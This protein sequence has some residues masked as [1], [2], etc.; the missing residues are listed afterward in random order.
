M[1]RTPFL[2]LGVL[3]AAAAWPLRDAWSEGRLVGAG[4]DVAVT[5]WAMWW[6]AAE[7]HG[8]VWTGVSRL[9][10]H[11]F[12]TEGTVLAPLSSAVFAALRVA[13]GDVGASNALGLIVLTALAGA[14]AWTARGMGLGWTAT[15]AAG[16]ALLVGRYP[17]FALGET[18]VVG[19]TAVPVVVGLG[20]W[21]R[22]KEGLLLAC[23]GLTALEYPYLAPVLPGLALLR[24]G[25]ERSLRWVAIALTG[26]FL[27]WLGARFIGRGQLSSFSPSLHPPLVFLGLRYPVIEEVHARARLFDLLWPGRVVWSLDVD[28]SVLAR[29]RDYLGLSLILLGLVGGK[30]GLPWLGLATVG[31]LLATGSDWGWVPGPFSWLNLV[32]RHLARA[33]TQPTRFL[34]LANLALALAAAHG[35]QR[36][37]RWKPVGVALILADGLIGGGLSLRLPTT[38]LPTASCV[39]SLSGREGVLVWPWDVRTSTVASLQTRFWQMQ[40][41]QP[42]ATFGVGSWSLVGGQRALDVLREQGVSEMLPVPIARLLELHYDTV[43]VDR[44][45]QAR[46]PLGLGRP[47]VTCEGADVY[48]LRAGVV[49]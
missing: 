21:V 38:A 45:E 32:A 12:G 5:L 18:S 44:R 31:A 9:V 26:L 40:H 16:L 30:R 42:G 4:P 2:I 14:T 46:A 28:G 34:L 29:G 36:M 6:F 41:G 39:A 7:W 11:P 49:P 23:A 17:F 24:A 37:G 15:L 35:I 8:A 10:N 20:A 48:F 47:K 13:L 25:R 33:L 27:V 43:V 3:A 19:I 1:S 22:R